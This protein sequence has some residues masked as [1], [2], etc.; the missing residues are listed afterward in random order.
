MGKYT[1]A[2]MRVHQYIVVSLID[3]RVI[4]S[5]ATLSDA[6]EERNRAKSRFPYDTVEIYSKIG[7]H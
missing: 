7:D 1:E 6:I 2:L 4:A 5:C 3:H